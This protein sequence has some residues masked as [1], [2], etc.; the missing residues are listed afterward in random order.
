MEEARPRLY[1]CSACKI[2]ENIIG[3]KWYCVGHE[4][5]FHWYCSLDCLFNATGEAVINGK[6]EN[7]IS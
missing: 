7:N 4:G 1:T 5:I 2:T 6:T 3:D